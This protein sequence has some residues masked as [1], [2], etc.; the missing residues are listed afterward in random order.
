M[1]ETENNQNYNE[2]VC[3]Q[4]SQQTERSPHLQITKRNDTEPTE[5]E[6]LSP[7]GG[8]SDEGMDDTHESPDIGD[9]ACCDRKYTPPKMTIQATC[10]VLVPVLRPLPCPSVYSLLVV[11]YYCYTGHKRFFIYIHRAFNCY[12][13]TLN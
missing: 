4:Y 8:E 12:C 13:F 1:P 5:L 3:Y 2:A 11:P 9:P 6:H 7:G 10:P